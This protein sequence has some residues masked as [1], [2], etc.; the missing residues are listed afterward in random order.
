MQI[1]TERSFLPDH[2]ALYESIFCL[3]RSVEVNYPDYSKWFH[4][5]FLDGL[6]KGER[7]III[8]EENGKISG[9]ALIKKTVWEKKLCT[10]FVCPEN[11]RQGIGQKLLAQVVKELGQKPLTS[12][13]EESVKN[14]LPL[15]NRFGFRLSARKKG[16]YSA[17][18]T[19][20][21][22]NDE[23]TE[24]IRDRLIPVLMQ[25][26]RKLQKS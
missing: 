16:I 20:Y 2:Q 9:V 7:A 1:K 25:R 8:A 22:F 19:E 13:S 23:H 18:K 11:R 4:Q 21:F 3:T 6:K 24:S 12:V 15:F 5:T 17:D 14:I 26:A 10:L